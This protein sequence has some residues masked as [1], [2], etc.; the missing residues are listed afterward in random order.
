MN[1]TETF[2]GLGFDFKVNLEPKSIN[3]EKNSV[4]NSKLVNSVFF[5]KN[6]NN[7]NTSFYLI[8]TTL[9]NYEIEEVRKYIWNKND[10]DIIFYYPNAGTEFQM[11]YAKYSPQISYKESILETFTP[12]KKD[13]EKIEKIK[14]WQFDS[15]VFWLNFQELI[16]KKK[17]IAIDRE[18]VFTL[19]ALKDQLNI[20]LQKLILDQNKRNKVVQALIDRTLY[21][22]YLE[23]KHIINSHFYGH[24]FDDTTLNYGKL[25][26]QNSD[27]D[28]NK[29]F[30]II[31]EIFNNGLFDQPTIDTNFLTNEI[32][33]LIAD[34]FNG[35]LKTGQLRL[36]DFQFNVLPV[37]FISYIYEVFLSDSQKANGIYYT[38]KKLAQLIVDDVI[39]EGKIGKIL[40]PACGSG[41][42]L[43][44]AF[45]R[46]LEIVQ[47]QGLE[48]KNNIEKIKYRIKLLSENIFG[49]EKEPTAQRFTLFSLSLQ[50]FKNIPAEEI[51]LFIAKEL[52][53]N[54]E[55]SL[56]NEYSFYENIVC[57][58][59]LNIETP[60]FEGK[61]FDYILGNPP[62]VRGKNV[63]VEAKVFTNSYQFEVLKKQIFALNIIE[64]YQISQCFLLK[65][66]EWSYKKT[67]FGF[68]SNSSNFYSEDTKFQNYFYSNYGIEKIYEL[69]R[70]K[71][72]LFE[73]AG[74]PVVA[75]IFAN[76]YEENIIDYYPVD[77]G[78]FSQK[79]FELL[80]IQVDKVIQ[81]KQ[82]KL[83]NR[84]IKLRDFLVGNEDDI[85]FYYKLKNNK[86]LSSYILQKEK[87]PFIHEGLKL[88][89]EKA[90][91]NEYKISKS[92]W[93]NLQRKSQLAYFDRFKNENS[94]N[95]LNQEF[96]FQLLKPKNINNFKCLKTTV[97]LRDNISNF[98][99]ARSPEI[100]VGKK[101]IF[102]RTGS[103][104]KSIFSN[105]KQYFDF[106]LHTLKLSDENLYHLVNAILNSNF[107]N[108]YIHLFLRKRILG[109]FPKIGNDEILNIPIPKHLNQNLVSQISKISQDLT[110]GKF[111]YYEK[112]NE[113]NELIYDLYDLDYLERQRV[114]DYFIA[115]AKKTTTPAILEN[116]K[117][118]L[119]DTLEFRFSEKITVEDFKGFNLRV[120]KINFG[121]NDNPSVRQVGL[122]TLEQIFKEN[123]NEKILLGQ[124]FI[125]SKNCFYIIRK[126][127]NQNFTETKAFEDGQHILKS[128]PNEQ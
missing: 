7:T 87:S 69:S 113:L 119:L 31:H 117:Q 11:L 21:I 10:A 68:V 75:I 80:I 33:G 38:P 25:L 96:L 79:P 9:E 36:F 104:L 70:V 61:N 97:F 99:R 37:E 111:E 78:L 16:N 19:T 77:L 12:S 123:P 112:E 48:P 116:Y 6:Q 39:I 42:F 14:K 43:I 52:N 93:G 71:N 24:Y 28:L 41:M 1:Y 51:R 40:D 60:V 81:V 34:S 84:Q 58:N 35:N 121:Q 29:L 65:I 115:N 67:R 76:N 15:G 56:F 85:N 72:I 86:T 110:D 118:A 45:Q 124:E 47:S 89:G 108:Y 3:I 82:E 53:D 2:L 90:I 128:I 13:E 22:K 126:D 73:E 32:R 102:T 122:Y 66:K 109:S 17:Y 83:K 50:I 120:V 101:I 125:F 23:D 49:I 20:D 114:K 94:S 8:G 106:D 55:I 59:S 46:L 57:E 127:I 44:V 105:Q 107:I 63:S 4:L 26:K 88:V 30:S 95:V 91:C 74:E 103:K 100:F 18:L 62:F 27:S 54:N 5:Y 92:D 64:G 98:E